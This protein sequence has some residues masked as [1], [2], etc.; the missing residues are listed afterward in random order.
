MAKWWTSKKVEKLENEVFKQSSRLARKGYCVWFDKKDYGISLIVCTRE[1]YEK[2][3]WTDSFISTG[4]YHWY[5]E[6]YEKY[7]LRVRELLEELKGVV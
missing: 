6:D 1:N 5:G 3:G 4:T 7:E 2:T